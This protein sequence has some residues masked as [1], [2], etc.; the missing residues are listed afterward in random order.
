M[1]VLHVVQTPLNFVGGPATYVK[2]L[3]ENLAK[4]GLK[5]GI[6]APYAKPSK[7]IAELT[8]KFG[9]EYHSIDTTIL[10]KMLLRDPWFFSIT[11]H[12]SLSE[13]VRDY[14]IINVHVESLPLQAALKS[15][16]DR[17]LVVTVHGWSLYEDYRSIRE[18]FDLYK[19]IHLIT[20]ATRQ[21]L[22][23]RLLIEN[24]RAIVAVSGYLREILMGHFPK[25][26]DKTVVIHNAVNT[27]IFRPI[28]RD[29]ALEKV[30]SILVRRCESLV[31]LDDEMSIILFVG[32]IGPQKGVDVLLKSLA[33]IRR[34]GWV[35]F[36]VGEGNARYVKRLKD[37]VSRLNL[38]S[39]VC[40][41]GG[42]TRVYLPYFYSSAQVFVLPSRFEGLPATILEAMACGAPVI[43]TRV[44]GIPEAIIDGVSG[45]LV[46]PNSVEQLQKALE[47]LL[48]DPNH[49][50]RL[51]K[52]ALRAARKFSWDSAVNQYYQLY[53][54]IGNEKC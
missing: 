53:R 33:R 26:K 52:T 9:I 14:D 38:K 47:R 35:L 41:I 49:R 29:M 10:P 3:A 21:Y 48:D 27:D 32:R 1:R 4:R 18:S 7:E 23:L 6:V 40:F 51:S 43:A 30:K 15:F 28:D 45:A 44:G 16:E 8:K 31:S 54:C 19:L 12:R 20:V 25:A 11:A 2:E 22:A 13:I 24:S 42:I 17:S 5:V 50:D 36:L 34:K 46:E 39:Q 37:M